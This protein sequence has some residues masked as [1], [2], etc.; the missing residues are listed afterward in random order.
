MEV[1]VSPSFSVP[2]YLINACAWPAGSH[3][4]ASVA[5]GRLHVRLAQSGG[6]FFRSFAYFDR[7]L[8]SRT[9]PADLADLIPTLRKSMHLERPA[10]M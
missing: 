2:G 1:P 3:A 4:E 6:R 9:Q 8:R 5:E 10:G 7:W